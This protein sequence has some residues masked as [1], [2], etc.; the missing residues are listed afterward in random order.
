MSAAELWT[1]MPLLILGAGAL[2]ILLL[3]AVAPGRYATAVGIATTLGAALWSSQQPL[4][5]TTALSG[6]LFTPFARF[7]TIFFA[8]ITAAVLL[9]AH[10]HRE[11]SGLRGEEYPASL[12]F[13]AFGMATVA[14]AGNLLTLFL[15]LEA[16]TFAFYI[17]V[18]LDL[19]RTG[20]GEAGLKYLLLGAVSAAFIAF[21][22]A[23]IF[24]GCGRLEIGAAM[25]ASVTGDNFL[26]MA[27]WGMIIA[28]I[29]FKLSLV[30]AHLWTPDVYQG[31]P[32]PVIALLASGSKGGALVFLLLLF[33]DAGMPQFIR[34]PLWCLSLLSML[35][36]NLA[37]LRQPDIR[38]MLG[39]SSVAQMGYLVLALLAGENGGF[40]AAVYYL[41]I[42]A[43]MNLAAFGALALLEED[44]RPLRIDDLRGAGFRQPLAGGVLALAMFSLAGIP[45]TAG[46]F[47]KFFI[48]YAALR[49]GELAIAI[50]GILSAAIAA[51]YYLRVVVNLYL[52]TGEP[53]VNKQGISIAG[54][55]PLVAASLSLLWLGIFPGK[56]IE[57]IENI[58]P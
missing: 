55:I 45:P 46:F 7:F 25:A 17:L 53:A 50:T 56:L 39:Y 54:G 8:L 27:G 49:Q 15:G 5:P 33:T 21:G 38:R 34:P 6:L 24:A 13:A 19:N 44:D 58:L 4:L 52:Q 37:A 14:A 36:G 26:A 10:D 31:G 57:L 32:A 51:Y 2:A 35:L 9:I 23:L 29:A 42:Y 18:A 16:L 28:G 40:E 48:F 22:I 41:L 20:S 43:A 11:K 3:G 1:L 47:G 12:L 30:P